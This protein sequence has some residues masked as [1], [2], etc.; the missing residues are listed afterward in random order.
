LKVAADPSQY[1]LSG[2]SVGLPFK[3]GGEVS[4]EDFIQQMTVGTPSADQG[5]SE[6]F[7]GKK[8]A[9]LGIS[10][11]DF[12]LMA[13][14]VP[15]AI[16]LALT[17]TP[18]GA[19]EEE[20]LARLRGLAAQE[21]ATT[22]GGA[23]KALLQAI[24]SKNPAAAAKAIAEAPQVFDIKKSGKLS[25]LEKELIEAGGKRQ[26][27]R[28]QRAADEI[29]GLENQ[30]QAEALRRAFLGKK[31]YPYQALMTLDPK[32]FQELALPLGSPLGT[33]S[34][35]NIE[36]LRNVLRQGGSFDEVP[37][38]MI[39]K[40]GDFSSIVGHE[41]RH[42]T[43][44]LA[45]EKAPKTLVELYPRRGLEMGADDDYMTSSEWLRRFNEELGKGDRFVF[46]ED[47]KNVLKLPEAYADGGE[48]SNDEYIQQMMTGTPPTDQGSRPYDESA[49]AQFADY[50]RAPV[51]LAQTAARGLVGSVVGPAYG[52][53]KGLTGGKYGTPEGVREASEAGGELM[54]RITGE[55]K[56][57]AAR[58]VLDFIGKKAE[59]YKLAPMPQLM[60]LPVPGPGALRYPAEAAKTQAEDIALRA[61]RSQTENPDISAAELYNA[62][63]GRQAPGAAAVKPRG[64]ITLTTKGSPL[65]NYIEDVLDSVKREGYRATVPEDNRA[66]V[67]N[68]IA[69]K[70]PKYI[71]S[72]F[73]TEDDPIREAVQS[74]RIELFGRDKEKFRG[75]A[76]AAAREGDPEALQDITR[77]Y[78]RGTG[79]RP[80]VIT[81]D[82]D[83]YRATTAAKEKAVENLVQKMV[84]EGADEDLSRSIVS[85]RL[86]GVSFKDLAAIADDGDIR[87]N[88]GSSAQ[89]LASFGG[90]DQA[91]F[92]KRAV[93]QGDVAFGLSSYNL[94]QLFEP[95][96]IA[97]TIGAVPVE[98]LS[99]MSFPEAFIEGTNILK[100]TRDFDLALETARRGKGS[101]LP[102]EVLFFGT[103]PQ[104]KVKSG[105]WVRIT[106]PLAAKLEGALMGHS[107]G[108]YGDEGSYN[109]GGKKALL[110]G[111][112]N[113]FSLRDEK[114]LPMTTVEVE[115]MNAGTGQAPDFKMR[116]TQ[117]KFNSAPEDYMDDVFDLADNINGRWSE[118]LAG[119]QTYLTDRSGK[120]LDEVKRIKWGDQYRQ[121]KQNRPPEGMAKGGEVSKFIKA[122]A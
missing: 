38:L 13:G 54:Q 75:Y 91:E 89:V 93:E 32:D 22:E 10:P 16:G 116:Q 28:L 71:R 33:Y 99:R 117:G 106:D 64:G 85:E 52:V 8:L 62:M 37:F 43:R 111:K 86:E 110:S 12:L 100:A 70:M 1:G 61:V 72:D 34:K 120:A 73:G 49:L 66:E 77:A 58:D 11:A 109:I 59:E 27:L 76:L 44:A 97:K 21:T 46:S 82:T 9:E 50:L 107:V 3:D 88:F 98:K 55:P 96:A 20:E 112:A 31:G 108:G 36:K 63:L 2:L 48:V 119:D 41:G 56:S 78:D 115:D 118:G 81:P 4:N 79:L 42:R 87:K 122:H 68:F 80:Y 92:I 47:E 24:K 84:A 60:T 101:T 15:S 26:G 23:A 57:Q 121:R 102:K 83:D 7:I 25:E 19:G 67:E 6:S 53:Y 35:Q 65:G 105:Q 30:Y 17:P 18:A 45:A 14:K 74:G 29:P 40:K 90:K 103:K 39:D 69:K 113:L 95:E 5:T 51:D 104:T 114:G 94:L